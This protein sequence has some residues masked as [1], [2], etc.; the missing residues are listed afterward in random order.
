MLSRDQI[1]TSES[2][3][4]YTVSAL[5]S[6]GT[7]QGDIY[8]VSSGGTE[9]ALKLFHDGEEN[10]VRAQIQ[11]LMRRGQACAAYVHP[12][13]ILCVDGRL[14]YTMEYIPD[15]Y[16][17]GS[18]LYNGVEEDGRR[19]ALPYHIKMSVLYN[20]SEAL[21]VLYNAN[22]ALM[23]LKFDNLKIH[24]ETYDIKILDTDTVVKSEEGH[25]LVAGTVGFMP[26][27]TM[28]MQETP[29]KY[30]D[31][32]AL[33]VIIFMTLLGS[34]PFVGKRG[35]EPLPPGSTDVE[36]YLFCEHPVYVAHP[37]DESN[38]PSAESFCT[39]SKL[40]KYP[41]VFTRAMEQTFVDGLFCREARTS[42]IA[43][44]DILKETYDA[45][46]CCAMC[47]EEHFF[48]SHET[49]CDGCGERLQ[50]PLLA[51]GE[52]TLPLYFGCPIHAADLWSGV[53]DRP[54]FC[55]VETTPYAGKYGLFVENDPITLAFSD[56]E[57]IV[58]AK[59]K[60]VPLFLGA[61]YVYQNK[62]FTLK[63]G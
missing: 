35:D 61:T 47:G 44:C 42:P 24:P 37:T 18:V 2:G 11:A 28:R 33:A 62:Y 5:I 15:T 55:R 34:H 53:G 1:L 31:S 23:D 40:K 32:F 38:R 21:A 50:K 58:F 13:D 63:E 20:L 39:A 52:R 49:V 45:S 14:G 27:L 36:N 7:A 57:S 19:V 43:W 10:Q 41:A 30:N 4:V 16:L 3:R 46:Y 59:G 60:I 25:A 51:V 8:R 26:P 48:G 12:L 56:G 22:L 29:G 9:Y 54:P 17:S 6:S